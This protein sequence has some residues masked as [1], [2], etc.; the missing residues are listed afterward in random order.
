MFV[1][2]QVG[3]DSTLANGMPVI[4]RIVPTEKSEG[5]LPQFSVDVLHISTALNVT[6]NRY[7]IAD[8]GF[9]EGRSLS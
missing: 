4:F 7:G 9:I 3:G 8:G 6:E 1:E 2:I 5:T